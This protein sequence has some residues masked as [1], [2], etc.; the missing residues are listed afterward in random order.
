MDGL[1]VSAGRKGTLLGDWVMAAQA[2]KPYG[3][4][5]RAGWGE[6]VLCTKLRAAISHQINLRPG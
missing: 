2:L 6:V 4:E 5:K 1:H 3:P